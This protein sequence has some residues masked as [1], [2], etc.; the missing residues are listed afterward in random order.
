MARPESINEIE[1]EN[2]FVRLAMFELDRIMTDAALLKHYT[3]LLEVVT[4][5]GGRADKAYST[6]DLD[7]PKNKK[8]LEDQLRSDQYN[9]DETQKLYRIA[10][11]GDSSDEPIREYQKTTIKEWAKREGL[12]DPFDV[13]AANDED[14][15]KLRKEMGLDND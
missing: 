10:L 2:R 1:E 8:Q 6:I 15:Q 13:F 3:A 12:P 11:K 4:K 14:I 9:W 7:I 5:M